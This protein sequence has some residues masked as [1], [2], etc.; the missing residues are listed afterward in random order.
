MQRM[1]YLIK[2]IDAKYIANSLYERNQF[3]LLMLKD[4][5]Y[6]FALY[7]VYR[8]DYSNFLSRHK[9]VQRFFISL[10]C[11]FDHSSI[12]GPTSLSNLPSFEPL[13][14]PLCG[15]PVSQELFIKRRLWFPWLITF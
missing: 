5:L 13:F 6:K 15:Q 7:L 12:H 9:K 1:H 11:A 2:S 10:L 14:K 8:S 3:T 4:M